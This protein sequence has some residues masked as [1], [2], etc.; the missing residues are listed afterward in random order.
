VPV[1]SFGIRRVCAA[2]GCEAQLSS[3]NPGCHCS[4][5]RGWDLEPPMRRRRRPRLSK[6]RGENGS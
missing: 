6:R 3:Y 4:I 1:R 5:H 2:E